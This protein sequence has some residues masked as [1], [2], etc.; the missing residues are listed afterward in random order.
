LLNL[1][2]V[3]YQTKGLKF[4][5]DES[6]VAGH[7]SPDRLGGRRP[8]LLARHRDLIVEELRRTPHMASRQLR[9]LLATRGIHVSH[10]TVWRFLRREGLSFKK[11]PVCN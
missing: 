7:V 9:D 3:A 2:H 4:R 8:V 11:K 5:L 10:D 1:R 6:S